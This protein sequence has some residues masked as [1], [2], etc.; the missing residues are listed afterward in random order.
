MN[1]VKDFLE[2]NKVD[3]KWCFPFNT[4]FCDVFQGKYLVNISFFVLKPVCSVLGMA[5]INDL[6][7]PCWRSYKCK[8]DTR[9]MSRQLSQFPKSPFL[10]SFIFIPF[11]Q[12][13]G[14]SLFAHIVLYM[15]SLNMIAVAH[16]KPTIRI[17]AWIPSIRFWKFYCYAISSFVSESEF[18]LSSFHSVGVSPISYYRLWSLRT[19]LKCSS[20]LSDC[21]PSVVITLPAASVTGGIW[22]VL[23]LCFFS[24]FCTVFE[25]NIVYQN[26]IVLLLYSESNLELTADSTMNKYC[27]GSKMW[28]DS[29]GSCLLM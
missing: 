27:Y 22:L 18:L 28:H 20:L 15:Y 21:S 8:K 23:P 2:I 13:H 5:S 9:F 10:W 26:H 19:V 14:I 6:S 29:T 12:S 7:R 17:S 16:V 4:L 1:T 25:V 3:E 24:L 11:D